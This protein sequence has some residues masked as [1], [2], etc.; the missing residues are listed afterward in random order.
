MAQA[1]RKRTPAGPRILKYEAIKS[2]AI[3]IALR[4][5]L[6]KMGFCE[7]EIA[8]QLRGISADRLGPA[9]QS[10][11]Y[12]PAIGDRLIFEI[13]ASRNRPGS[14]EVGGRVQRLNADGSRRA[15]APRPARPVRPATLREEADR[16][17]S[18]FAGMKF[19]NKAPR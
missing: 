8:A 10:N 15:E 3:G 11:V 16:Q 18:A 12:E 6:R 1:K 2:R 13:V 4:V 19:V 14:V 9:R 17:W 7:S 5:R